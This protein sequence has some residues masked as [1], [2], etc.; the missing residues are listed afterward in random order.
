MSTSNMVADNK[1]E[2]DDMK[3]LPMF[4]STRSKRLKMWL[5]RK[6]SRDHLGLEEKP[7]RPPQGA[8]AAVRVE[9]KH[10][11]AARAERKDTCVSYLRGSA[12]R[13]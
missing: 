5:M 4:G 7:E 8:A 11:L 9:Y 12:E 1:M 6:N 10:D 3:G 2:K 13:T